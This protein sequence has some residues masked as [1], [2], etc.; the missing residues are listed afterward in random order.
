MVSISSQ[1]HKASTTVILFFFF[2]KMEVAVFVFEPL[3]SVWK[4]LAS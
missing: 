3:H 2:L 1:S 4:Y